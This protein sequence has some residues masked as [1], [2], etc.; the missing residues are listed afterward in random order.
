[1]S[2]RM[3]CSSPRRLHLALS[4]LFCRGLGGPSWLR[5][6]PI[7]LLARSLKASSLS[8]PPCRGCASRYSMV[9]LFDWRGHC[10]G[11]YSLDGCSDVFSVSLSLIDATLP[12]LLAFVL[13]P[14]WT[15][16]G[17]AAFNPSGVIANHIAAGILGIL[18]GHSLYTCLY[19]WVTWK[20]FWRHRLL[21]WHG[22]L[23]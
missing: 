21:P 12:R 16:C 5:W 15:I 22:Q 13:A 18:G 1:M 2:R 6:A 20:P 3:L 10:R 11:G 7:P 17:F 19:E 14:D 9:T 4:G 23:E 8:E